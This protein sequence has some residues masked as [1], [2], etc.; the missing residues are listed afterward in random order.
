M[1]AVGLG[2]RSHPNTNTG[3]SFVGEVNANHGFSVSRSK[4]AKTHPMNRNG[5]AVN[6]NQ[7][8]REGIAK[9][10]NTWRVCFQSEIAAYAH[11]AHLKVFG[12]L[13]AGMNR[14]ANKKR[15]RHCNQRRDDL[16]FV[17]PS[18]ITHR[19]SGLRKKEARHCPFR[20]AERTHE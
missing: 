7:N 19:F 2:I 20:A 1:E 6:V 14:E 8:V 10:N 18:D 15:D 5:G 11:G 4:V 9:M 12:A 16:L 17:H 13:I 3:A